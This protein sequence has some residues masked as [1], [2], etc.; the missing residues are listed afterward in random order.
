MYRNSGKALHLAL[1]RSRTLAESWPHRDWKWNCK[2]T[3][4][5]GWFQ[6]CW[7]QE[8]MDRDCGVPSFSWLISS[9]WLFSSSCWLISS[10]SVLYIFLTS[11]FLTLITCSWYI[12][13]SL[14]NFC[15]MIFC[16]LLLNVLFFW[17]FSVQILDRKT[18]WLAHIF[19]YGK[20]YLTTESGIFVEK[21][22][23]SPVN[24]EGWVGFMWLDVC[25]FKACFSPRVISMPV[26]LRRGPWLHRQRCN[27]LKVLFWFCT[28]VMMNEIMLLYT[29]HTPIIF[30]N[31]STLPI[32]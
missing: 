13:I 21:F 14:V 23:C 24:W 20:R 10:A 16:L 7:L 4:N 28:T 3:W 29:S 27:I 18:T 12:M 22:G 11:Q 2:V 9:S 6:E 15:L 8:C 30:L 26:A 19:F 17:Y 32:S 25:C 31:E 5:P 1:G